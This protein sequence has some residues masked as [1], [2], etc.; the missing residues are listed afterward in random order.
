M[1]LPLVILGALAIVAGAL[2]AHAFFHSHVLD[3]WLDP[4]FAKAKS[5]LE[6]L[7]GKELPGVSAL[8]SK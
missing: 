4:V 2:N 6:L 7:E 1:T 5:S 3:S 8:S